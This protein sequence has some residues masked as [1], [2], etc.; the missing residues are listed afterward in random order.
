MDI[1]NMQR[2]DEDGDGVPDF[3]FDQDPMK[4]VEHITE[5][6]TVTLEKM[7]QG[8]LEMD[9]KYADVLRRIAD[10]ESK[11]TA[12]VEKANKPAPALERG[13]SRGLSVHSKKAKEEEEEEKEEEEED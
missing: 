5:K 4:G 10:M 2:P 8:R 1:M 6:V 3:D 12:L 13:L 11:V 7:E 9:G